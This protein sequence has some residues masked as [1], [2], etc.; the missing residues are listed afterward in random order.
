[1]QRDWTRG[2]ILPS[3]LQ[4]GRVQSSPVQVTEPEAPKQTHAFCT[5]TCILE[6]I[7]SLEKRCKSHS[8]EPLK[9]KPSCSTSG[10]RE[11]AAL[12]V[13]DTPACV[14]LPA[15]WFS[16]SLSVT[17][18]YTRLKH[19]CAQAGTHAGK[20]SP[21]LFGWGNMTVIFGLLL[22]PLEGEAGVKLT[23]RND[24]NPQV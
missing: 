20:K 6:P 24:K 16:L 18:T 15:F 1:M 11:A 3:G 14:P 17:Q 2:V 8:K 12:P 21:F 13:R 7:F 10:H 9:P 4:L 19:I 5:R 22:A 23:W